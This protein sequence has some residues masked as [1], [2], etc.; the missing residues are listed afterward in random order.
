MKTI[1]VY[2]GFI[3]L[4]TFMR[5]LSNTFFQE[6]EDYRTVQ[7]L[8]GIKFTHSAPVLSFPLLCKVTM[9]KTTPIKAII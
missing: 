1:E 9:N 2:K 8:D 3:I 7:I 6:N 5:S 4:N